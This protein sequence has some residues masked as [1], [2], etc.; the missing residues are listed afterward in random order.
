MLTYIQKTL[1]RIPGVAFIWSIIKRVLDDNVSF[2]AGGVAFYGLLSIFPAIAAVVSVYGLLVT[3]YDVQH[4]LS[5]IED[6]MPPEAFALISDQILSI[7]KQSEKTLSLTVFFSLF[8]TVYAATK[9]TKAM[10]A[11]LNSLHR[12][13][14]NRPWWKQQGVAFM[15]TSGGLLTLVCA[16]LMIVAVPIIF[17]LLHLPNLFA[18]LD[19]LRWMILSI[20]II[21]GLVFLFLF[22]PNRRCKNLLFVVI[23]AT[24]STGLWLLTAWGFSQFVMLF[25]QF[26]KIYG[27]L[28][29]VMVLLTWMYASAYAVLIGAAITA[30]SQDT[31]DKMHGITEDARLSCPDDVAS[32]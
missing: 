31:W 1:F 28:G 30:V 13:S 15:L 10:L 4:H 11:A 21:I 22:G 26:N 7:N 27:S 25:P 2:L 32:A 6:F 3:G 12:V 17:Q 9:G 20:N 19:P 5:M 8:F 16:L 23:G 14:E 29:A 24:V 18:Q